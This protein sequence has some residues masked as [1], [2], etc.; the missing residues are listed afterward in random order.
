MARRVQP[1]FR[2]DHIGSLLRPA[3][4]LAA[5]YP[6]HGAKPSHAGHESL[7]DRCI[8]AAIRMQERL[9]LKSITDGEFRRE[10]WRLGLV[11]KAEGFS[12]A[13]AVG[14][15]DFQHDAAGQRRRIG[16]APIATAKVR[17]VAPIVADDVAFTLRRTKRSVKATLPSP[18]Y[19]HYPRGAACVDPTIYPDIEAF[20]DDVVALYREEI[21]A[22]YEVGGR[23]LQIDEV[24][25]ALLCDDRLR[26]ALAARGDNP[27][28]LSDL[29]IELIN[30]CIRDHPADLVVAVHM[31]RGNAMGSW[32]GCGGY[33]RIAE[34]VFNLL[35]VDAFFLEYD[36]ER[37]G[38]FEPLRLMPHDKTVVL[39]L[40]STKSPELESADAL[41]ARIDSAAAYVPLERLCLSPQCGFASADRG[42][43]LRPSD[44]EAKLA[45]VVATAADVWG[46]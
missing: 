10:S 31:C 15:V 37:A 29:Y 21:A 32:M 44:Q 33:Q 27:D 9:G 39:G 46:E 17:W 19:L 41:K 12:R 40:V 30:R 13:D 4:L 42:T 36:T 18:S 25:Q 6:Q 2:A 28:R 24:A 34:R 22:V 1:P 16:N 5:R 43:R 23:Y 20:F 7:E 8:E 3:E 11:S 14:E 45:L 35:E 38:G 26:A